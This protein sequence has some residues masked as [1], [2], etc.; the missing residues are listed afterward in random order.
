M[1]CCRSRTTLARLFL[2]TVRYVDNRAF[3]SAEPAVR[4]V[5]WQVNMSETF[6]G[7]SLLLEHVGDEPLLGFRSIDTVQRNIIM[8][9]PVHASQF[10]SPSSANSLSFAMAGLS[11]AL[12]SCGF[13]RPRV[14]LFH[15]L[16]T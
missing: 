8:R 9:M 10:R 15:S 11:R 16:K 7:D 2:S 1:H 14:Q 4:P 6:H 5:P 13:T 3:L 12:L